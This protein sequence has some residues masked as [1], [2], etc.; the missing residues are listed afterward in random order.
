MHLT[1]DPEEYGGIQT[2]QFPL[3]E[4]FIPEIVPLNM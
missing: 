1:W 4:I 3:D 2:I